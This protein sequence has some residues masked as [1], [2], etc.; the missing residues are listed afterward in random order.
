VQPHHFGDHPAR[1]P[2][3]DY[4]GGI[5]AG[6]DQMM[7]L[8]EGEPLPPPEH[9]WQSGRRARGSTPLPLILFAVFIGSVV[10]RGIF[11][12]TLGSAFTAAGAGLLVWIAGYALLLALLAAAGAFLFTLLGA[13]LAAAAGRATRVAGASAAAWRI[14]R[15]TWGGFGGG[16]FSGGGGGFGGGG[17]SGSW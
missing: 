10:L 15:R 13:W 9:D 11:G 6:L 16:G 14:R 1:L 4:Y 5:D 8:I 17:A 2:P 7:K 3:G 12:R